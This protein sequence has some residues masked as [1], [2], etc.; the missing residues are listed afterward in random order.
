MTPYIEFISNHPYLF[1]ALFIVTVLI[2]KAEIDSRLSGV[3][4][5]NVQEAVRL[6]DQ[7]GMLILDVREA[8]EYSAGH[9]RQALHIPMSALKSRANELDKYK[10]KTILAYCRSGNRSNSACR[11]LKKSGFDQ[12]YNLSG[13]I[14]AWTNANLPVTKK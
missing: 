6:M 1:L 14:M 12:I 3:T 9:L 7:E 13:G 5:S 10:N 4:Q 2:I 11:Q 8:S